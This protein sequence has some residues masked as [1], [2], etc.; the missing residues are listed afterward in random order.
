MCQLPSDDI[1]SCQYTIFLHLKLISAIL[2]APLSDA[3][4]SMQRLRGGKMPIAE[5]P[6]NAA[7]KNHSSR[8]AVCQIL[9]RGRHFFRFL[10]YK[11]NAVAT[12]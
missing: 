12:R 8:Y 7:D 6:R 11:E 1:T 4:K 5:R 9:L 10:Q 3:V 2:T